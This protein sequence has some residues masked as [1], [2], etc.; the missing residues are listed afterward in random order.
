MRGLSG[1]GDQT[2]AKG[3][4][5]R[6]GWGQV[7]TQAVEVGEGLQFRVWGLAVTLSCYSSCKG[8]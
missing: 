3:G 5:G 6:R 8:V 2:G 1:G 4:G 7:A